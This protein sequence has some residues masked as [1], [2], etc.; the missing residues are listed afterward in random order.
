MN[1]TNDGRRL[2][3]ARV[4]SRV[5]GRLLMEWGKILEGQV[6]LR[7]FFFFFFFANSQKFGTT[8]VFSGEKSLFPHNLLTIFMVYG[9]WYFL[10][11]STFLI[12]FLFP[13]LPEP[14][15]KGV[16]SAKIKSAKVRQPFNLK[17]WIVSRTFFY[18]RHIYL[19]AK[20]YYR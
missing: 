13:L 7:F 10:L 18:V 1:I 6:L 11:I 14:T 12:N 3:L 15:A 8:N 2:R 17:N 20:V 19:F 5:S 4:N 9:I 16:I